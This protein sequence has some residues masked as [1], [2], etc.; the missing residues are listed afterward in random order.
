MPRL[1][2]VPEPGLGIGQIASLQGSNQAALVFDPLD[3]GVRI[4]DIC[5]P[6]E[7]TKPSAESHASHRQLISEMAAGQLDGHGGTQVIDRFRLAVQIERVHVLQVQQE[8]AAGTLSNGDEGG[9][10]RRNAFGFG[11]EIA[12]CGVPRQA[13]LLL[14]LIG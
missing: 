9:E 12:G 11:L 14:V 7:L 1:P 4:R 13:P 6:L 10:R 8:L 3:S 5:D 2:A